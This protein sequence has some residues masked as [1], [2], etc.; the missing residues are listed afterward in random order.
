VVKNAGSCAG[1]AIATG[2][3]GQVLSAAT[4]LEPPD[5]QTS[6]THFKTV[7]ASPNLL[8]FPTL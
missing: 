6:G 2:I 4:R 3:L 7:L 1:F 8:V 5:S